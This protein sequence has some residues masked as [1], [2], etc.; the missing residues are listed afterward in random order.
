MLSDDIIF[1][2]VTSFRTSPKKFYKLSKNYKSA[3]SSNFFHSVANVS[4]LFSPHRFTR[5][6]YVNFIGKW[7][8]LGSHSSYYL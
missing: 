8:Q 2:Y 6:V 5:T 7:Y 1:T 4:V 3:V